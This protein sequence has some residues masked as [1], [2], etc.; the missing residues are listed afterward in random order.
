[1]HPKKRLLDS[2]SEIPARMFFLAGMCVIFGNLPTH[3]A[4]SFPVQS[5][6]GHPYEDGDVFA[7][8]WV[9]TDALGRTVP[10][11]DECGPVKPNKWVGIFYW[12]GTPTTA[13]APT[14][15]PN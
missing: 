13:A 6:P 8:T 5:Y 15:I 4:D 14:I 11:L 3:A 2:V 10:G 12:T 7:D 1:M 9:A